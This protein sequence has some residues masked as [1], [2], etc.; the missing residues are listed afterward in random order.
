MAVEGQCKRR[1]G[2]T[3]VELLTV[4]G[5]VA[6]LLAILLP[7]VQQARLAARRT[8]CSN[9]LRQIALALHHYHDVHNVLPPGS[10]VLGPS[11]PVASGWGWGAMV[12]PWL[13]QD[14]L[15]RRIDFDLGTAVGSNRALIAQPLKIW[16]CVS[17]SGPERVN[18]ELRGSDEVELGYGTYLANAKLMSGMSSTKFADVTDGLSNTVLLGERGWNPSPNA[19]AFSS[20]W[21]GIVASADAYVFQSVP[22]LELLEFRPINY[23]IGGAECFSSQHS[24]GAQFALCDGSV[25]FLS[26]SMDGGM[27]QALGTAAGGEQRVH[28]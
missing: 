9:H 2:F 16:R 25:Q 12:L 5:I 27:F 28:F 18:V 8:Q 7:A 23:L 15:Y 1:S 6:V 3:I 26:E 17:N 11:F 4:V 21:C 19:S 13:E 10:L 22:F 20:S 14:G 24:G